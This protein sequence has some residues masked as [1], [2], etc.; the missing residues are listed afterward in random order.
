MNGEWRTTPRTD[1]YK[2]NNS[3]VIYVHTDSP[4]FG[5]HWSKDVIQFGKL[6]LTNNE[7]SKVSDAVFLKSLNKYDPVLCVYRHDRKNVDDRK[8]VYTRFFKETQF[9]AV[10][11]YQNE[12]I[13]N[14]KIKHNPFAKAFLNNNKPVIT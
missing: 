7:N 6:K 9:I 4:N 11:A 8:L 3:P 5:L 12:M 14:L 1:H 13:T 10:T 2:S